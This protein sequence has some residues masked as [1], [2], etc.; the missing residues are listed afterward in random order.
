M[1]SDIR[2]QYL[3]ASTPFRFP[4]LARLCG[5]LALGQGRESVVALLL[6]T[7][8][9]AAMLGE[10]GLFVVAATRAQAAAEWLRASCPDRQVRTAATGVCEAVIAGEERGVRKALLQLVAA[11]SELLTPAARAELAPYTALARPSGGVPRR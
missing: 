2:P 8:I 5:S 10:Q 3:L 4:A 7:R 11:T 1:A 6:V 9:A